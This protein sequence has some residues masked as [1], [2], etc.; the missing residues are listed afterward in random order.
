M[1]DA[2]T[3]PSPDDEVAPVVAVGRTLGGGVL[4]LLGVALIIAGGFWYFIVPWFGWAM[5]GFW[6]QMAEWADLGGI[7]VAV[8]G[9]FALIVG[10]ALIQRA[11]KRG[12][13]IFIN[14]ADVAGQLREVDEPEPGPEKST[15]TVPKTII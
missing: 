10:G 2:S 7:A 13:Q 1:T 8:L 15:G 14:P 6:F 3:T 11:R 4:V 12:L 5:E 9:F